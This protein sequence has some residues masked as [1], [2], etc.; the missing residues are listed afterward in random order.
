VNQ[1]VPPVLASPK[2]LAIAAVPILG[3]LSTP[4]LPFVNRPALWFGI[5]SVLV[6]TALWVV[7]TVVALQVVEATYRREGGGAADE[8]EESAEL[9]VG[10]AAEGSREE[11]R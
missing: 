3:F 5:P 1:H 9:A 7:G 10:L 4:L 6:W 11:Q 8:A 2:R